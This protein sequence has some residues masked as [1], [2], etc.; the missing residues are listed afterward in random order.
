MPAEGLQYFHS[1]YNN[2]MTRYPTAPTHQG[3]DALRGLAAMAVFLCHGDVHHLVYHPF[4]TANKAHFAM[5]GVHLFFAISGYLIWQSMARQWEKPRGLAVYAIHRATRIIPLYYVSIAVIIGVFT[6]ANRVLPVPYEM[7]PSW[8]AVWRHLIFSQNLA[9]GV[10]RDINGVYWTLTHEAIFYVLVPFL[11]LACRRLPALAVAAVAVLSWPLAWVALTQGLGYFTMFYRVFFAF[12]IGV[13][14]AH[15]RL[16][17]LA[18]LALGAVIL[19]AA[20]AALENDMH[21]QIP[22]A[23]MALAAFCCC[24]SL[25][26][27]RA[28]ELSR[29]PVRALAPVGVVS[30]SFYIWHVPLLYLMGP[31]ASWAN[32]HLPGWQNDFLRAVLVTGVMLGVSFL[33]YR[34]IERPGMGRLRLALQRRLTGGPRREPGPRETEPTAPVAERVA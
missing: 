30:Y 9:P 17:R 28:A 26:G 27:T 8:Y 29:H 6:L 16:P 11:F 12:M 25:A 15:Y 5:F 31:F 32:G 33:S 14:F 1:D 18:G 21:V 7:N 4:V 19:A 13:I 20:V 23:L 3:V 34:Y 10:F 22:G 2:L 24:I